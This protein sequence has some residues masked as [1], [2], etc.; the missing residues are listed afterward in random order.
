[1]LEF[2][3]FETTSRGAKVVRSVTLVREHGRG[4]ALSLVGTVKAKH[5]PAAQSDFVKGFL[6]LENI[7]EA[8]AVPL[9]FNN[10]Q[11]RKRLDVSMA[12]GEKTETDFGG[13]RTVRYDIFLL[14]IND[15]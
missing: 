11:L 8:T 13:P 14:Q 6:R 7:N 9:V 1:M 15:I 3:A 5:V 12:N 4:A 2:Q 10:M